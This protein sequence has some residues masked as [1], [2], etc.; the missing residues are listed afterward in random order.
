MAST[1]TYT[2]GV[3]N[4]FFLKRLLQPQDKANNPVHV[5]YLSPE[6]TRHAYRFPGAILIY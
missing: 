2:E 6:E 3:T 1:L 5:V 4:P